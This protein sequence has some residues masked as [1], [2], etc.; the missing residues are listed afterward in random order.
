MYKL[1]MCNDFL[2]D[3]K[4]IFCVSRIFGVSPVTFVKSPMRAEEYVETKPSRN[5]VGSLFSVIVFC[6]MAVGLIL[7]VAECIIN[8]CK[9]AGEMV[10]RVFSHPLLFLSAGV[11]IATHFTVNRLKIAELL[12]QLSSVNKI[13]I[14]KQRQYCIDV[15]ERNPRSSAI[16]LVTMFFSHIILVC[17]D[18]FLRARYHQTYTRGFTLNVAD[19]VI[20]SITIQFCNFVRCIKYTLR[21]L[22]RIISVNTDVNS[23]RCSVKR[24]FNYGQQFGQRS[25]SRSAVHIEMIKEITPFHRDVSHPTQGEAISAHRIM[26]CRRVYNA[27][28]EAHT[29]VNSIYGI[30]VLLIFVITGTFSIINVYYLLLDP[31]NVSFLMESRLKRTEE[32]ILRVF[33]VFMCTAI[34]FYMSVSCHLVTLESS[35][36]NEKIQKLLLLNSVQRDS[37]RQLKLFSD[38][39][40]KNCIKFAASYFFTIDMSLFCAYVATTITYTIVLVQ[41]K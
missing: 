1:S 29:L 11:S 38:Q 7:S 17:V 39:L 40:S 20:F 14:Q 13:V 8:D 16:L 22:V 33:W 6:A 3:M 5:V 19:L 18:F 21:E 35:K 25:A 23:V 9:D 26:F 24:G 4:L 27:V 37:V 15:K 30:P 41:F 36:L 34:A 28:Y 31:P 32:L 10:H 2:Y 12:K